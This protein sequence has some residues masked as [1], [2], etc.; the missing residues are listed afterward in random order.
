MI[1]LLIISQGNLRYCGAAR[2][3]VRVSPLTL[4]GW[5]R[6]L[7]ELPELHI[8]HVR[9]LGETCAQTGALILINFFLYKT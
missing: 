7:L 8:R 9:D 3:R 1:V 6:I 5:S 2:W 4:S